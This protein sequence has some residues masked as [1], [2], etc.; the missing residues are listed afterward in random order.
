MIGLTRGPFTSRTTH[1][2]TNNPPRTV[3]G[4]SAPLASLPWSQA[5]PGFK[6]MDPSDPNT[7]I[8]PWNP[9]GGMIGYLNFDGAQ[10]QARTPTGGVQRGRN[11]RRRV[12]QG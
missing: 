11:K 3:Y 7:Y 1:G 8:R 9:R 4:R 2:W 6:G 10:R 5:G 12:R